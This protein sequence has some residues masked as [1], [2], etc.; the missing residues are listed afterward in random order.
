MKKGGLP[1]ANSNNRIP[2]VHQSIYPISVTNDF[3]IISGA[4]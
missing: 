3:F 2:K 4:K 1:V